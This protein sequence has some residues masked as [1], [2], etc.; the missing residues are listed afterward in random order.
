[1]LLHDT[2]EL[3]N[4]LGAWSNKDLAL[5]SFLGVVDALQGIVE[6]GGLDHDGD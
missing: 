2:E 3:D 1:M 4:N 6:D 5:S